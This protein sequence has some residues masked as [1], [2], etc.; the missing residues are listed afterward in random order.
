MLHQDYKLWASCLLLV[1]LAAGCKSTVEVK[2]AAPDSGGPDSATRA[3][4]ALPPCP[5][6]APAPPVLPLSFPRHDLVSFWLTRNPGSGQALPPATI[7][8]H[9][10]RVGRLTKEGW[11]TGRWDPLELTFTPQ[12]VRQRL[13]LKLDRLR[14]GVALGKRV[15][16]DGQLPD[17]LLARLTAEVEQ[18]APT[19]EIHVVHRGT[20]IRCLATTTPI[21]EK[22]WDQAFDQMQ[23]SRLHPGEPVRVLGRG[24]RLWYVWASYTDGWVDPSALTPPLTRPQVKAYLRPARQAV[25]TADRLPLWTTATGNQLQ[26]LVRM[27]LHLPLLGQQ[28]GRLKVLA[29]TAT[30]V[31][32]AW[33]DRAGASVGRSPLTRA[34]LLRRA[35]QLLNSTYGWGGVGGTRD[36]SRLMMD[37]FDTFGLRLPRNSW[38]QSQSGVRQVDVKDLDDAAKAQAIEQAGRAGVVLL[39]LPGHI[40]LYLGRDGQRLYA[41]HQF[42]GYLVPC[43]GGGETMNR[44]NRAAVTTLELGRGS[45]RRAFI[46]RITK[47]VIFD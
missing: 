46:E 1:L 33:I 5:A 36:C 8:L 12:Q 18:L 35:F 9:N 27:G 39:Y 19:D 34:A 42:S 37:L 7:K 47:L 4:A 17:A 38:N 26:G 23:C 45:S 3:R 22:A 41:L 2:R 10:Q 31:G 25:V 30:G 44:V 40:M 21:Y 20:A 29:P 15:L 14:K 13:Q 32:P 43:Q 24:K 28:R 6:E 11:P 16:P